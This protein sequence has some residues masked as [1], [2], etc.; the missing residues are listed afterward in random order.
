MNNKIGMNLLLWGT[1]INESLFPVLEEIKTIIK[2][3]KLNYVKSLFATI[4]QLDE[5]E[6]SVLGLTYLKSLS[7]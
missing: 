4:E 3:N 6:G 2:L 1:E 5:F 7:T